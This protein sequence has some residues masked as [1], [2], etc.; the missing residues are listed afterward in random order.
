MGV[1]L[2]ARGLARDVR[3]DPGE[4]LRVAVEEDEVGAAP[5]EPGGEVLAHAPGRTGDNR[6]PA[7]DDERR[8][9]H[10]AASRASSAVEASALLELPGRSRLSGASAPRGRVAPFVPTGR[11]CMSAVTSARPKAILSLT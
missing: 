4:T 3:G 10:R 11:K 6:G 7:G 1:D 5:G 8:T 9:P 2:R